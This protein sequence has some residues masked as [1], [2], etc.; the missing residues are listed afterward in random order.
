M[1]L[2]QSDPLLNERTNL[3][4]K[5]NISRTC[6]LYVRPAPEYISKELLGFVRVFNMNEEQLKHWLSNDKCSN[7]L[8]YLDCGLDTEVEIKTWTFLKT[9]ISLLLKMF[10]TTLNDDE[11]YLVANSKKGSNKLSH[12]KTM[13]LNY[14]ICEKKILIDALNFIDERIKI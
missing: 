8:L 3:L 14:R 13:I 12:I 6:E 4:A 7:D 2:S 5:I 11:Q 1:G 9:R 10:P